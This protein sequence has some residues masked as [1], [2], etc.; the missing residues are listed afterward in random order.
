MANLRDFK[1]KNTVFTGTEGIIIPNGTTGQRTGTETGKFRYNTETGLGELYTGT[2]WTPLDT[3]PTITT[4]SGTINVDTESTLTINGTNFKSGSIVSIEGAGVSGIP[5]P[6][7]T[8]FVNAGQLTAATNA[9]A[10]NYVGNAVFNV[11]VT[12]PSGLA[13]V[14]ENAGTV[15]RDPVWSTASGNLGTIYDSERGEKT[16][17]VVATDPD[18]T[19]VTYSLV[20]GSLPSN[21]TLNAST[22]AITGTPNAVVSD[23]TSTFTIRATS[24]N[25]SADR[26]FNIIVAAPVTVAFAYTGSTQ[27]WTKPTGLT[28]ATIKVWGAA[29][30]AGTTYFSTFGGPGGYGYATVNISTFSSLNVVVG[31]AG[32]ATGTGERSCYGHL[33]ASTDGRAGG[34]DASCGGGGGLS[35]VFNGAV[36]SQANAIIIAAGGGGSGQINNARI[37]GA[38]GPGGGPNQN[39]VNGRDNPAVSAAFGRGGT[40]T[41]GGQS[42]ISFFVSPNGVASTSVATGGSALCGGHAHI[43]SNWTEGGGGGSGYFGG[44]S[45]AHEDTSGYWAAAGGGSGYAN[46]SFCSNIVAYTGSY[47]SQNSNATSDP[48]WVSGISVPNAGTRGGNGRVVIRY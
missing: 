37:D 34:F 5:R 8:T 38:G 33:L 36:T 46:T 2:G 13:A 44:G 35:G 17:T 43:V 31:E 42:G 32:V 4:I 41:A 21:M 9:A 20:S 26:S 7:V 3:P 45:G 14:L 1:N 12:N 11:K 18:G 10:V 40:T 29:G 16:F 6:L 30:S 22:G 39:G 25:F 24:N 19:S 15:D 28:R 48:D 27:T 47:E 23:T